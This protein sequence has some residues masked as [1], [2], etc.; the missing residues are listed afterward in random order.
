L[1][2]DEALFCGQTAWLDDGRFVLFFCGVL[3]GG[4]CDAPFSYLI[5]LWLRGRTAIERI[6]AA[7]NFVAQTSSFQ[8][9]DELLSCFW[10]FLFVH[11][12]FYE[13]REKTLQIP[14]HILLFFASPMLLDHF[15]PSPGQILLAQKIRFKKASSSNVVVACAL[16]LLF[17]F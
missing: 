7:H 1:S 16:S 5:S 17:F 4:G 2:N 8:W 12:S 14:I 6:G 11:I 15:V 10:F 13:Y 3:I 9:A